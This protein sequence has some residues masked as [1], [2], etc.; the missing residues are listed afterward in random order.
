MWYYLKQFRSYKYISIHSDT[1]DTLYY[2]QVGIQGVSHIK[3]NAINH[4][5]KSSSMQKE[6]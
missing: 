3:Y 4:I 1:Q 6:Q 2:V 5:N